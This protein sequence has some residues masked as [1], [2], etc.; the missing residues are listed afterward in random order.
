MI[1]SVC[2]RRV[3]PGKIRETLTRARLCGWVKYGIC[4]CG[5]EAEDVRDP[6]YRKRWIE[7][8]RR[9]FSGRGSRGNSRKKEVGKP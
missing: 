3:R 9:A 4:K 7:A 1:C 5:M 2:R 6:S 8:F